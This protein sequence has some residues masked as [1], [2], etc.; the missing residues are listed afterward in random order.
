MCHR[1]CHRFQLRRGK[2]V[3]IASHPHPAAQLR[4]AHRRPDRHPPLHLAILEKIAFNLTEEA[5][6]GK[7]VVQFKGIPVR[8]VDEIISTEARVV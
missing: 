4:R 2:E 6:G 7:P 8:R 5:V 3:D 1:A